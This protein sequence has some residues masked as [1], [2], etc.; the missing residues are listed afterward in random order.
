MST[1]ASSLH[2]PAPVEGP[3]S[4]GSGALKVCTYVF[5]PAGGIG[6]YTHEWLRTLGR[7]DGVEA[8]L[9][10]APDFQWQQ[11]AEYVAW[12]GLRAL[13]HPVPLRRRLRFLRG[14]FA[15]PL[16]A[17]QQAERVDADILHFASVNHLTFPLWAPALRRL[18]ARVTIAVH[19]VRRQKAIVHRVWED[20]QLQA[21]YRAADALFVHS[22]YQAHELRDFAGVDPARIHVVPHGPYPYSRPTADR[23]TLRRRYGLPVDG[24]VALFFGQVR[25][26]KNLDGFIRALG[27]LDAPLYGLVAGHAHDRHRGM[28]AY[29]ALAADVGVDDRLVFLDRFIP[30]EEVGDLFSLADWVALPYRTAFTSQ[31]G[32]LNVAAHYDRPVLV[33]D[34]PVLRE[35]VEV[36]DIGVAAEGDTPEALVHGIER[37]MERVNGGHTFAFE[38]YRQQF[39]WEENA[40]R[41]LAVYRAL[42][43]APSLA[44]RS[45]TG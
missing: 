45:A 34:A 28:A 38:A 1:K 17:I 43:E 39:S 42:L 40:R 2:E 13:S 29:E 15:N 24:Q 16:R 4:V 22:A 21:V 37:I 35:T 23:A 5:F 10:C 31:S 32:V 41:T 19:D 36:C 11:A 3:S 33:S 27:R 44:V 20:R 30:D 18:R 26:E 25:D 12:P 14:Q 7:H 8:T 9:L 6:R